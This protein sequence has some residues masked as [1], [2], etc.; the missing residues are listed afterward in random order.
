MSILERFFLCNVCIYV[1]IFFKLNFELFEFVCFT[2]LY[3]HSERSAMTK[4]LSEDEVLET[5]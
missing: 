1:T 4:Y 3:F 5:L 2:I